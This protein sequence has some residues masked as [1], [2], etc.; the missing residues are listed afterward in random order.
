MQLVLFS[1]F[2]GCVYVWRLEAV[3]QFFT[4]QILFQPLLLGENG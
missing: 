4:F 2:E 1:N 3:E